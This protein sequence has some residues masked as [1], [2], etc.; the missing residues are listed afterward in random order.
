M[1]ES[2]TYF[3][4]IF[5]NLCCFNSRSYIV[6]P[7]INSSYNTFRF[8]F[9]NVILQVSSNRRLLSQPALQ[10]QDWNKHNFWY[11]TRTLSGKP[12]SLNICSTQPRK[13]GE[14]LPRDSA[15][16][17]ISRTVWAHWMENTFFSSVLQTL[18]ACSL[19]TRGPSQLFSW[20]SQIMSTAFRPLMSVPT[21]ETVMA[22]FL[23][24]LHLARHLKPD[25]CK[26][27]RKD[28][29]RR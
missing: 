27:Q 24:P 14:P 19:T 4:I 12:C 5:F 22:V 6:S 20:H 9:S 29:P 17:G 21:D 7:K 26:S 25:N 15:R 13:D 8:R 11:H 1:I 10:L 18:A 2:I 23:C 28:A 3:L 16:S